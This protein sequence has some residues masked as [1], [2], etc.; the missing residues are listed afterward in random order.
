MCAYMCVCVVACVRGHVHVGV[1]GFV[2]LLVFIFHTNT[3]R[4]FSSL[5]FSHRYHCLCGD[6]PL[7]V[8][9]SRKSPSVMSAVRCLCVGS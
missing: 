1:Y 7:G 4:C 2:T 3:F 6:S 8:M 9:A 5:I